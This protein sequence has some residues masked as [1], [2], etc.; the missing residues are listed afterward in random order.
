[1]CSNIY[2]WLA[3]AYSVHTTL[4]CFRYTVSVVGV[5]QNG[6]VQC[7]THTLLRHCIHLIRHLSK[8]VQN[9]NWVLLPHKQKNKFS[10]EFSIFIP[11]RWMMSTPN[12]AEPSC[13]SN[14]QDGI[15]D[16]P[17]S[18]RVFSTYNKREFLTALM[19]TNCNPDKTMVVQSR[20]RFPPE[21]IEAVKGMRTHQLINRWAK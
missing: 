12:S 2:I 21:K 5:G 15:R 9:N 3:R 18:K 20:F 17:G 19:M 16:E 13:S 4:F 8:F 11:F 6:C 7:H 10:S 14:V 1:M